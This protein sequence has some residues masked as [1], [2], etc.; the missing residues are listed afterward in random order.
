MTIV[1]GLLLCSKLS[2]LLVRP[3]AS[4]TC[5]PKLLITTNIPQV[6]PTFN[7]R[8]NKINYGQIRPCMSKAISVSIAELRNV[9]LKNLS[10]LS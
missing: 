2:K 10:D 7:S 1:F 6:Y 5:K 9:Y 3:N 8:K 4:V